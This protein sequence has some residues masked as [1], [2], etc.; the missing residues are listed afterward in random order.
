MSNPSVISLQLAA[1]S[2]N[3]YALSQKPLAAGNLI[4]NGALVVSGVGT[5]DVPRRVAIASDA[6][7]AGRTFTIKG[8]AQG[9]SPISE[10]VAGPNAGTVSSLLDYATI[11]SIAVDAATAGNITAGTNA[12]ASTPWVLHSFLTSSWNLSVAV[13]VSGAAVTYQVEHTYDD[14]NTSATLYSSMEPGSF[15]P[16]IA[17]AN[18]TLKGLTVDGE[19]QYANW[20]IFAHRLT[21]TAG[22]G[23][24]VMQSIQS[25]L[26][27]S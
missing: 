24:A 23:K 7:D 9:G 27:N 26:G 1:A 10:T 15:Q 20:P 17:W 16:P 18:P 8:I 22:T 21:I 25:G 13:H 3:S 11:T 12:T 19:F 2:A 5:P 4:L 14:P 6:N